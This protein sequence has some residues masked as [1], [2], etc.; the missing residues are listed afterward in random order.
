MKSGSCWA[1]MLHT[2]ALL[3]QMKSLTSLDMIYFCVLYG[4]V[5]LLKTSP[6]KSLVLDSS[7]CSRLPDEDSTDDQAKRIQRHTKPQRRPPRSQRPIILSNIPLN[8]ARHSQA[9]TDTVVDHSTDQTRRNSLRL[10]RDSIRHD[11]RASW[12]APV[13]GERHDD[14]AEECVDPVRLA[15]GCSCEEKRAGQE[16]EHGEE[17]DPCDAYPSE[18]KCH[19]HGACKTNRCDRHFLCDGHERREVAEACLED[20]VSYDPESVTVYMSVWCGKQNTRCSSLLTFP[21]RRQ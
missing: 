10:S 8:R 5:M 14:D 3:T 7:L 21:S 2:V 11:D 19:R 17:H 15:D 9:K 18:H 4:H 20:E 12:V 13:H 1:H 16:S 6:S